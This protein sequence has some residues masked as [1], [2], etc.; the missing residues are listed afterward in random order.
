MSMAHGRF[1][2]LVAALLIFGTLTGGAYAEGLKEPL[3]AQPLAD[4]LEAFARQTGLQVLYTSDVA[5]GV[6]SLGASTGRS[7]TATLRELLR[8]TDLTYEFVNARTVTILR[9]PVSATRAAQNNVKIVRN[10][11]P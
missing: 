1:G 3:K 7:T 10:P 6:Q 11:P 9:H 5:R 2:L 8:D 4:A